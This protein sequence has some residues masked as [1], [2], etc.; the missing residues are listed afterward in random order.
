MS[1][2]IS[3]ALSPPSSLLFK[4]SGHI[5]P[6]KMYSNKEPPKKDLIRIIFMWFRGI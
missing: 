6:H 2:V 3:V 5:P 1:K 4:G